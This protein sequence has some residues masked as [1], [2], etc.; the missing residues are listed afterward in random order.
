MN[1]KPICLLP[2]LS[3]ALAVAWAGALSAF[4]QEAGVREAASPDGE[5]LFKYDNA[6]PESPYAIYSK[7]TGK[8]VMKAPEETLTSFVNSVKCLWAPDSKCFALNFQAGGRYETALVYRRDGKTF[9]GLPSFEEMLAAELEV[10]KARD[11]KK[12]GIKA[13]AYQ[14]RIWDCFKVRRWIDGRTMEV[15]ACSVRTVMLKEDEFAEVSGSL[16]FQIQQDKKGKWRIL[17][18]EPVKIEEMEDKGGE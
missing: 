5:F 12:Q 18:R 13:D 11:M 8:V 16:R 1:L 6:D 14:R 10:E 17:K 9:A 2:K 3:L 4:S 15:D 7:A